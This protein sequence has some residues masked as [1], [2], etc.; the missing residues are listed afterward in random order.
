MK[1]KKKQI[2]W[3]RVNLFLSTKCFSTLRFLSHL[4]A[5]E[6]FLGLLHIGLD[7]LV[8]LFPSSRADLTMLISELESLDQAKS[9]INRSADRQVVD[10]DLS[11]DNLLTF[12]CSVSY[13]RNLAYLTIPLGSMMNNPRRAT[14]A[15]SNRTPYSR[16]IFFVLSAKMGIFISPR[17]PCLRGVLIHAR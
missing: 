11:N 9:F 12:R 4:R 6:V 7:S 16:A 15:S 3:S 17:P 8:S 5:G 2:F 14:P 13:N 1:K 10:G